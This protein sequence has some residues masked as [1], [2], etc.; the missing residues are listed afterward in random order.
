MVTRSEVRE[1]ARRNRLTLVAGLASVLA[2]ALV[3]TGFAPVARADEPAAT[4]GAKPSDDPVYRQRLHVYVTDYSKFVYEPMENVAG[5]ADWSPLPKAAKTEL[6]EQSLS[7]AQAYAQRM[8]STALIVWHKG[9]V[10]LEWYGD[11]LDR[12]SELVSKSLSKPLAAVAVGR[13][14]ALGKIAS[15]DQPISD[16]IPELKGTQKGRI[17]VRYLLDMRSG[18]QRQTFTT[19][20]ESPLNLSYL[21]P[22]HG[23]HIIESYPMVAE[24]G[25]SYDYANAPADLVAVVIERAT[26]RRYA[27]FVSNEIFKPIGAMGGEFWDNRPGGLAHSG[28]CMTLPAET[29]LRLGILLLKDGKWDGKRLL[30]KGY[31]KAMHTGTPQN[32]HFGL[33]VWVGSPYVERRGFGAPDAPGPKVLH[34]EPYLDPDLYL[35]DGNSDQIVDIS[36][37]NDLIVLRMGGN[38]P[39]PG[40]ASS[41]EWDN[42]YL[43]NTLIRGLSPTGKSGSG[44]GD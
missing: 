25:T 21:S 7:D 44:T 35:F 28:C 24:P 43:V 23:K 15:L 17:L 10:A 33:G 30:P 1:M 29:F 39:K 4:Q 8:N 16:F 32:P 19:D 13:A 5:A 42:T 3:V 2:S 18:M 20:P 9:K 41:Q 11:G 26:G 12:T 31:V 27:E 38:P 6:S 34:S 22:E 37:A 14:I 40:S 36:P